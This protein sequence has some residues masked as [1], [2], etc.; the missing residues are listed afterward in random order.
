MHSFLSQAESA[1]E[2]GSGFALAALA[3]AA[4][5]AAALV[6]SATLVAFTGAMVA[7]S[8]ADPQDHGSTLQRSP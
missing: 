4:G 1:G 6:T 2:I 3:Q 7:R 8:R 5:S